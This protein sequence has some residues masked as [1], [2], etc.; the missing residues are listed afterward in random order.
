MCRDVGNGKM[1][2]PSK[3]PPEFLE[4]FVQV[5]EGLIA[6]AAELMKHVKAA[7]NS[8]LEARQTWVDLCE[9]EGGGFRDVKKHEVWFLRKYLDMIQQAE[10]DGPE[11]RQLID[12]VKNMQRASAKA[13]QHWQGFCHEHCNNV[14]DPRA[15]KDEML[16]QWL[17]E[18]QSFTDLSAPDPDLVRRV[19][20]LQRRFQNLTGEWRAVCDRDGHGVRDPA[21]RPRTCMFTDGV[22][23]PDPNLRHL[24]DWCF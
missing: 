9:S 6:E 16:R 8:S 3:L 5:A 20:A 22:G 1:F 17:D 21:R 19:K 14:L 24:V 4:H 2:D 23:A 10:P 15:I 12:E 7:Q 13:K 11:R 18:V